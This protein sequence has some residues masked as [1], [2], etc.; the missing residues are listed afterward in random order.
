[1]FFTKSSHSQKKKKD[2]HHTL[3]L[4][5]FFSQEPKCCWQTVVGGERRQRLLVSAHLSIPLIIAEGWGQGRMA[6]AGD[7]QSVRHNEAPLGAGGEGGV[8][9]VDGRGSNSKLPS[10]QRALCSPR[11]RSCF[12]VNIPKVLSCAG[13]CVCVQKGGRLARWQLRQWS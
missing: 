8:G 11:I 10:H 2:L 5:L 6:D 3:V 13:R 12:C 9:T 1:M 7:P 4:Y